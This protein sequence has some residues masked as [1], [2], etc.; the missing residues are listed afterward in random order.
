M[1]IVY[2]D[3]RCPLCATEIHHYQRLS[4]S[5]PIKYVDITHSEFNAEAEGVD[6]VKVHREMHVRLVD[7]K[8][9]IGVDAF[10][11]LW[12][13]FPR[14]RFAAR[15]ARNPIFYRMLKAGYFCFA[16]IRPLLPRKSADCSRSPYCQN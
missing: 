6:P 9:A 7:G 8:L 14:Y 3:G 10:I 2:F 13:A 16:K 12:N 4:P 1:I 15:W 5:V 11:A